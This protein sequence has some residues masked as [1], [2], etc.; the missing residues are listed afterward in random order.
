MQLELDITKQLSFQQSSFSLAFSLKTSFRTLAVMGPSGSGKSMFLKC[1][2]GLV[3][4]HGRIM[5]NGQLLQDDATK[6]FVPVKKRNFALVPQNYCLYPHLNVQQ[7][8]AFNLKRGLFNPRPNFTNEQIEALLQL[9]NLESVRTLYPQH[10]SQ[11]QKQRTAI[12]RALVTKPQLL[13]LDEPFSA[14]DSHLK[15]RL[16]EELRQI[17]QQHQI[18]T[19]MVTHDAEDVQ[20]L[21]DQTVLIDQ[22]KIVGVKHDC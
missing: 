4:G 12:A 20:A 2:A 11:G 15:G 1:L 21:A 9:F 19:I 17:L 16:R 18:H 7:N 5:L 6:V 14:L 10:L 22:G 8:I 3:V 13:L